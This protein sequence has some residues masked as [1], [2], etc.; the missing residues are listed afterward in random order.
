MSRAF[1]KNDVS[2]DSVLVPRRAP[3][4]PG[5]PNYVTPRGIS[6]LRSEL[7]DLEAER[8]QFYLN[9]EMDAAERDYQLVSLSQRNKELIGRIESAK[10]IEV[11][12]Q[13]P[14]RVSFGVTVT[15]RTISGANPKTERRL[16]I[17]GVDEANPSEGLVSFLSPIA[18][19]LI[20]NSVGDF[21]SLHTVRGEELLEIIDISTEE[22]ET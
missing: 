11:K 8:A 13:R 18:K 20:G 12:T 3:L 19:A 21:I 1:I 9:T 7:A 16:T 5:I 10:V 17:V 2:N 14:D 22:T 4:P 15:V 6:L